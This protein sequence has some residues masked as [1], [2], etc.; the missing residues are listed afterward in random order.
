MTRSARGIARHIGTA[1]PRQSQCGRAQHAGRRRHHRHELALQH[2]RQGRHD[3]RAGG[4]RDAARTAV[5]HQDGALRRHQVQLARHA[6][7]RSQH[8]AAL[9][10]RAGELG[11][12]SA[13][14]RDHDGIV[15]R[16]LDAG[17][18]RAAAQRNARHQDE[19]DPRL[20]RA[21][22]CL[23]R[24]GARRARRLSERVLLGADLDTA[25]LAEGQDRPSRSCN[26]GRSG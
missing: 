11:R 17:V 7:L 10:H 9:A 6:K 4:Q 18:L 20:S 24:H 5:R 8:G 21:E 16:Q 1:H 22:R 23:P 19:A 3:H 13:H 26:T 15:G 12:R 14:A 2:R 25:D